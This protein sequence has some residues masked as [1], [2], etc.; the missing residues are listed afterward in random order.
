M[1]INFIRSNFIHYNSNA[2]AIG[3]KTDDSRCIL[4]KIYPWSCKWPWNPT[5]P[6]MTKTKCG[7]LN[8]SL[9]ITC[10]NFRVL[11]FTSLR[12]VVPNTRY[13]ALTLR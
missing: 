6:N 10:P 2:I 1:R 8:G 3:L 13:S 11:R 7:G 5:I 9:F 4:F 12:T